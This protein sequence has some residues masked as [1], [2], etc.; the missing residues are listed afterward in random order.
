MST[1]EQAAAPHNEQQEIKKKS[2]PRPYVVLRK[3]VQESPSAPQGWEFVL[4]VTAI[5]A[6]QAIRAAAEVLV[7][8]SDEDK[9]TLVAVSARN[10]KPVVVSAEIET[11]LK[12]S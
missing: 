4:N 10:F 11:K 2:E 8:A 1:V 6:E 3:Q 12:F 9:I 5:S 7:T